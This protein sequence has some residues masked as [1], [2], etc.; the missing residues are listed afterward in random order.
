M[1]GKVIKLN[2]RLQAVYPRLQKMRGYVELLEFLIAQWS[3]LENL[4][5][6]TFASRKDAIQLVRTGLLDPILNVRDPK[7][8]ANNTDYE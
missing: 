5:P 6:E 7:K 2:E 1:D 8:S 3:D 4:T